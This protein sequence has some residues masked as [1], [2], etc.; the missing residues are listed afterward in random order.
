MSTDQLERLDDGEG[1]LVKM[2]S[3]REEQNEPEQVPSVSCPERRNGKLKLPHIPVKG[4]NALT[5]RTLGRFF[6]ESNRNVGI[7]PVTP[8]D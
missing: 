5:F 7:T 3:R 8:P 2:S 1:S 4:A 6:L